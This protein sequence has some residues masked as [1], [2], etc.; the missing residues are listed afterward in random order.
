MIEGLHTIV[1]F[2]KHKLHRFAFVKYMVY[3]ILCILLQLHILDQ[4]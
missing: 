4:C 1:L 3:A 2:N